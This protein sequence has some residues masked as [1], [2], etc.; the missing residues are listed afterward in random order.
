MAKVQQMVE[1]AVR[2]GAQR[3]S[4]GEICGIVASC[5]VNILAYC[6][7]FDRLET[8]VL[9]VTSDPVSARLTLEATGYT[10]RTNPVVMVSDCDRIGAAAQLGALLDKAGIQILYSYASSLPGDRFFAIFKTSD[11][12]HAMRVL[13]GPALAAAA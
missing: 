6:S 2:T 11:D 4:F 13:A 12:A 7:Y 5:G 9:L 8:V 10:C 1:L 3:Q